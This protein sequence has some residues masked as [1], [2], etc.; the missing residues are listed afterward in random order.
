[1]NILVTRF[2]SH[3][4]DPSCS[5]LNTNALSVNRMFVVGG[6]LGCSLVVIDES[7]HA[8]V[9]DSDAVGAVGLGGAQHRPS[10]PVDV[11]AAEPDR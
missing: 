3:G 9:V 10:G 4:T 6:S 8:A 1:M 11:G 7:L 5:A 2:G